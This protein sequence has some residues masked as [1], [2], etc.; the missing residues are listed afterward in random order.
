MHAGARS[1]SLELS[2]DLVLPSVGMREIEQWITHYCNEIRN[3]VESLLDKQEVKLET[4]KR[5]V[6]VRS[7]LFQKNWVERRVPERQMIA[8][9][10]DEV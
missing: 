9:K 10:A 8:V 4:E 5:Q 3:M 2:R 1:T 6:K 7:M